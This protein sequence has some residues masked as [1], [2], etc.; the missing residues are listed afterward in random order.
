MIAAPIELLFIHNFDRGV[1]SKRSP[2]APLSPNRPSPS[3]GLP[4]SPKRPSMLPQPTLRINSAPKNTYN[5]SSAP[6]Y[7]VSQQTKDDVNCVSFCCWGVSTLRPF[8]E[9]ALGFVFENKSSDGTVVLVDRTGGGKSHV[10]RCAGTITR[11]AVLLIVP[12][13]A[14]AADVFLKF[15]NSDSSNGSIDAIH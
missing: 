15:I 2:L 14:L 12:L 9:Y 5:T 11:G 10:M 3:T 7:F 1:M 13:L 8:Q 6:R 4:S